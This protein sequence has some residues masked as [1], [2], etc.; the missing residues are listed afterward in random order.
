MLPIIGAAA[1]LSFGSALAQGLVGGAGAGASSGLM[2]TMFGGWNARR[3]WKY[4]RKAMELQQQ[5]ALE[6]MERQATLQRA[7]F[8]YENEYNTPIKV[9]DRYRQAGIN[10]AAVLGSSGASMSATMPMPSAPSG[11][12][13]SG[14][15]VVSGMAPVNVD[16]V[17]AS[18]IKYNNAA[19]ANQEASADLTTAKIPT[20]EA[21]REF[22]S[23]GADSASAKAHLDVLNA[24]YQA[25]VNAR[26]PEQ[27]DAA[28]ENLIAN[29]DK[30]LSARDVD[31]EQAKYIREC[32]AEVAVKAELE[33]AMMAKDNALTVRIGKET[34]L[35][36][37]Q[38]DDLEKCIKSFD[39]KSIEI[40]VMFRNERGEL[41]QGTQ[42]VNGYAAKALLMDYAA[43][44]GIHNQVISYAVANWSDA[45]QVREAITGYVNSSAN[46]LGSIS[47]LLESATSPAKF[48]PKAPYRSPYSG[49]E[50]DQ[51][52]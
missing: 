22:L 33:K 49:L 52:F 39:H 7:Q 29:T 11:G 41:V 32:A 3:Q 1:G 40:P 19:A 36:S 43:I 44:Q 37:L 2:G 20:E 16:P 50:P 31:V 8:D 21:M 46:A 6:Q 25:M 42:K 9:F 17:A 47:R 15:P 45:S 10:P 34:R 4:Q 24:D 26:A 12:H 38:G 5:Y 27:I 35:L 23:A 51:N 48:T 13:V 14:G 18:Q 30:L 28:I